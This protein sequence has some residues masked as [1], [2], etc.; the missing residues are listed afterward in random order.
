MAEKENDKIHPNAMEYDDFEERYAEVNGINLYYEAENIVDQS[1]KTAVVLVHGWTANRFRIHP[2][3]LHFKE[4]GTPVFRMDLRGH[5]WSQKDEDLDYSLPSF[6]ED[7]YHFLRNIVVAEHGFSRIFLIG[8]SMGGLIVQG[9]MCK[10]NPEF[11]DKLALISTSPYFFDNF[12]RKIGAWLEIRS[13]EK[14]FWKKFQKKKSGEEPLG[15]EHFPQW[16]D[17]FSTKGR[18]LIPS[19]KATIQSLESMKNYDLRDEIQM[20][21]FT[22]PTLII[23]GTKDILAPPR[24]AKW[25][26]KHYNNSYLHVI[27]GG[28]HNID[29]HKPLTIRNIF[30]DF[31]RHH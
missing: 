4:K 18:K 21:K 23:T 11:V 2:L 19:K 3:F 6:V 14:D 22:L 25:M 8:H 24:F 27:E 12:V 29:I 26:K 17:K 31:L 10:Y 13:Y 28:Q 1:S 20:K 9:V 30:D 7:V 16:F 5:G 15:L